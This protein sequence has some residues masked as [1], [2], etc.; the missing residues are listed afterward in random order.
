L[1]SDRLGRRILVGFLASALVIP[2]IPVTA[3][4]QVVDP[5][6]PQNL[7]A[8]QKH[9]YTILRW[10]PVDG[11]GEYEIYRTPVDD[12]NQP[13]DD[14]ELVGIWRPNRT[15]TPDEPA[16]AE[17]GYSLG[18]RFGWNV[19]ARFGSGLPYEVVVDA[20]SGAAGTYEANGASFG[21]SADE[22][23]I[24]G[25]IELGTDGGTDDPN[26][27]CDP[28][29][30]FTPG[31]VALV[32][33]GSC[34][35]TT[36]AQ[37]AQDAG[38]TA[39][40]VVNDRAGLPTN[41]GGTSASITIPAVMIGQDDGNFIKTGLP[42]TG[43]VRS[44]P[45]APLSDAVYGRTLAQ[46]GDPN[47]PNE[48]MRT[49]WE[50]TDAAQYTSDDFEYNYTATIDAAS[51]RMRVDQ[52]ATTLQGRAV[53]LLIFGYPAPPPTA[54]AIAGTPTALVNCNVHGN[55]PSS[56]EACFIL[57]R[58]L[59]FSTDPR[60]IDI[61]SNMT[62]LLVP[63]INADGRANNTRGNATGQDLNRD[64]S[65]LT[66]P[67]TFGFSEMLRD[68]QPWA[69]FDGHEFGNTNAG[70]LP[71]LPPRHLNVAQEIFDQSIDMIEG[72]MYSAG[73]E[74]GWWFCPY[75]CAGGG[76]VGLGQETILRNT[77]GLKNTV[78]SLLEARSSGGATRPDEGSAQNN[79]RR[80][81]Y[82]ALFTYQEFFDY[83]RANTPALNASRDAA[84]AWQSSNTGPVY[85]D[86]TRPINDYPAPHPGEDPPPD[87]IPSA[88]EIL[89]D[90][91]CGYFLTDDQVNGDRNDSPNGFPT[92]AGDRFTAHGWT[93]DARTTGYVVRLAQP[94][95][96]LIPLL[97]DD[98]APAE[99]VDGV[100]L[101]ECPWIQV[102]P[103]RR[104]LPCRGP[105]PLAPR[106]SRGRPHRRATAAGQPGVARGRHL[107]PAR[108]V[109]PEPPRDL[110]LPHPRGA[111]PRRRRRGTGCGR[112][113]PGPGS[114]AVH[115]RLPAAR[116][117]RRARLG[118]RA[119]ARLLVARRATI[120][121]S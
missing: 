66:Q 117:D 106:R 111:R 18:D 77:S 79:R 27:V 61:L 32:D 54:E 9:G 91:P 3:A 35:F 23:G 39:V 65:L 30:G 98:A 114:Q 96:G 105:L 119:H 31:N 8:E 74:D 62:V 37:N 71:V 16:F 58:E 67:E 57:A 11:A 94:L 7:T 40:I 26:E 47:D 49:Q 81:S 59:A 97:L 1:V 92:T 44:A 90:P 99:M 108:E 15:V 73:S 21:P 69:G 12:A 113:H 86:G 75:G 115:A 25:T 6:V 68:Y 43:T 36:K 19:R 5:Q 88:S 41:M 24:S 50:M 118:E 89:A 45:V 64:H 100:R 53:N 28:L 38:A 14:M 107:R 93:T 72:H 2:V 95:R 112:R 48:G 102:D 121:T 4:A 87:V 80:K 78:A 70:D 46:W 20:P 10:D 83:F 22:T 51:D 34:N 116:G 55:E 17:A 13:T 56:R 110:D 42:A 29:V 52:I 101:F 33:R 60:I 103:P 84:L 76:N 82:S 120:S 104:V 109:P 85:L 63:S